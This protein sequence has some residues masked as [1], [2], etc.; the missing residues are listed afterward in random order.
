[1]RANINLGEGSYKGFFPTGL[2]T[3]NRI[4]LLKFSD[5]VYFRKTLLADLKTQPVICRLTFFCKYK[6]RPCSYLI[7]TKGVSDW[8]EFPPTEGR[9][10]YYKCVCNALPTAWIETAEIFDELFH[11]FDQERFFLDP[12]DE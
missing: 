11:N 8:M 9:A 1:M 3:P 2:L 12:E 10:T 5:C 4:P 6:E 7:Y